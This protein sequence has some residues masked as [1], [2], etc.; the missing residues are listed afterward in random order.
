MQFKF[1]PWG[2]WIVL[3]DRKHFKVKLLR[4]KRG[5]ALSRQYHNFR[6]E[7]WLFLS[8]GGEFALISHEERSAD[9]TG[10][11]AVNKNSVIQ[12][13]VLATHSFRAAVPSWVLEIQY[14]DKC[15]ESDIVRL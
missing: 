11:F 9:P 1:R 13:G 7:L 15:E 10:L 4:F 6:K 14:G 12:V 2:F 3:L 8:G 5:R